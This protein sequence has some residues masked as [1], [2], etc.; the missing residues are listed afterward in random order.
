[1]MT[2][3]CRHE[4]TLTRVWD[5]CPI[6]RTW[7]WRLG[8]RRGREEEDKNYLSAR[9]RSTNKTVFADRKSGSKLIV[10]I[11][12]FMT[13]PRVTTLVLQKR[14]S[15]HRVGCGVA[16]SGGVQWRWRQ[17]SGFDGGAG[18]TWRTTG[19][20]L[21]LDLESREKWENKVFLERE[22]KKW[23]RLERFYFFVYIPLWGSAFWS[24]N[25]Q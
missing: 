17:F 10:Q 18:R 7:P 14:W 25:L 15:W 11:P 2:H 22:S 5:L 21:G 9:G 12:S 13:R 16:A 20:F 23:K 8:A 3:P 6:R 24:S 1:M 4:S 19:H